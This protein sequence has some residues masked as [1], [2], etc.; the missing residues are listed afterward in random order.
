MTRRS[1]IRITAVGVATLT[2][3]ALAVGIAGPAA[4]EHGTVVATFA[5]AGSLEQGNEVRAAGVKVG[6]I[7]EIRLE[8]GKARVTLDVD[9]SVLPLHRD[10]R[11]KVRPVN[12]LGENYVELNAGSAAQPFLDEAIIP[13]RQ[14]EFAV[15]LQDVLDT[16]HEP[17]AAALASMLAAFGE[18]MHDSGGKAAAALAALEPAMTKAA[19]FGHLLDQQSGALDELVRQL[20]PVSEALA[21]DDGRLLDRL[22]GSTEKTLSSVAADHRSLD[23]TLAELPGT[24]R[25]ARRTL[26]ELVGV[27]DSATPTLK[28]LRPITG[29]LSQITS[30]LQRF[31]DAA[32]PALTSLRPVL[33]HADDLFDDAGPAVAQLRRA[34]PHLRGVAVSAKPLSDQL[35]DKHLGDLMAFVRKWALST[36]GHDG[37]SHYFRG[38]VMVTPATLDDLANS[39]PGGKPG[40]VRVPDPG[41][42][43]PPADPKDPGN[44]T[45]LTPQQEQ[46]MLGQLLGGE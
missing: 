4:P 6:Q 14:T 46:S 9:S 29:D 5:D 20:E 16:F 31:A 22:L 3:A 39:A 7:D 10:A 42:V 33:R 41:G 18:G 44:A 43:Q 38:V 12:L 35:L 13:E 19:D 27:A 45:G 17:T 15:T 40:R 2:V 1:L 30:E 23:R 28:S 21:A 34:G 36:N 32:D 25:A 26:A 8:N 11:L 37:I 24:V